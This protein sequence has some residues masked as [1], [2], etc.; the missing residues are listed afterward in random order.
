MNQ[1]EQHQPEQ[2][3]ISVVARWTF[4]G[5]ASAVEYDVAKL[6]AA[7]AGGTIALSIHGLK[8]IDFE[9]PEGDP[10]P[11]SDAPHFSDAP[12]TVGAAAP[13]RSRSRPDNQPKTEDVPLRNGLVQLPSDAEKKKRGRPPKNP[14]L[15]AVNGAA[16]DTAAEPQN[17]TEIP[18]S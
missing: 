6:V 2:R 11:S 16:N 5:T 12:L 18:G 14:T 9:P 7:L 1:P 15:A 4:S 13:S 10:A 17:Q 3:S 8:S